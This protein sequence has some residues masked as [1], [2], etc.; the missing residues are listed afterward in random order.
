MKGRDAICDLCNKKMQRVSDRH[1]AD[2]LRCPGCGEQFR[3][4]KKPN[5]AHELFPR[6]RRK[7]ERREDES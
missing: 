2:I 1:G 4:T 6:K 7:R 3:L 5:L